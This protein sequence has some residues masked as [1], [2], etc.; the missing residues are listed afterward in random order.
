M[1]NIFLAAKKFLDNVFV[2]KFLFRVLYGDIL[3]NGDSIQFTVRWHHFGAISEYS[4][5]IIRF[6]QRFT[7][8][9]G[10]ESGMDPSE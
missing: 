7:S 3:Q 8:L 4:P 6:D 10:T 5:T 2:R 1:L 9:N